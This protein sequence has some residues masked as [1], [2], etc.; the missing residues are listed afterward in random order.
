MMQVN[1]LEGAA[2]TPQE[3]HP[4]ALVKAF[5]KMVP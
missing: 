2:H 4:E 5:L 1:E 3:T